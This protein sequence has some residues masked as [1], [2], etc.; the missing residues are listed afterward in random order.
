MHTC[1]QITCE[2]TPRWR[3]VGS[4][5][6]PVASL[7]SRLSIARRRQVQ[8][9]S[10]ALVRSSSRGRGRLAPQAARDAASR[11]RRA[12][13]GAVGACWLASGGPSIGVQSASERA[14]G[15]RLAALASVGR[16]TEAGAGLDLD[17]RERAVS[18]EG[19]DGALRGAPPWASG[20]REPA[21]RRRR[22]R[23][24]RTWLMPASCQVAIQRGGV[25]RGGPGLVT[26]F[27]RPYTCSLRR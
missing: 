24:P 23:A 12:L 17:D 1:T 5:F 7:A 26:S 9:A 19:G 16:R 20:S 3:V 6:I 11:A 21:R 27:H 15:S 4:S 22:R 10:S 18:E 8:R 2:T 13:R 14:H 25:P